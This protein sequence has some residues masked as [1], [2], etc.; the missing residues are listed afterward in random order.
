[1][2]GALGDHAEGPSF[3]GTR[4]APSPGADHRVWEAITCRTWPAGDA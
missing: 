4:P 1:M 3:I 2:N